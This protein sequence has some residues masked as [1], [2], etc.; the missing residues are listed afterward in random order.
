MSPAKIAYLNLIRRK[1]S[2]AILF[3]GIVLAVTT[4]GLLLRLYE[5]SADRFDGLTN[6]GDAIVGA[7]AGP[8]DLLLGM[9]NF[10]GSFPEYI[11][12][13]LYQTLKR[14]E[15]LQFEDKT[16]VGVQF[17]RDVFPF[18]LFAKAEDFRVYATSADFFTA[19]NLGAPKITA[20]RAPKA[21]NE[22]VI[23]DL[24]ARRFKLQVGQDILTGAWVGAEAPSAPKDRMTVT[25]IIEPTGRA[26][27]RIALA[28]WSAPQKVFAENAKSLRTPW[29]PNILHFMLVYLTPEGLKPLKNLINDRTVA[30]AVSVE[31]AT[32][33]LREL[34]GTGQELGLV[35]ASVILLLSITSVASIMVGRF[36]SRTVQLAVLRSLG[37]S[38]AD[39]SKVLI[40]EAIMITLAACFVGALFDAVL[41]P[42]LRSLLGA[43]IPSDEIVSSMI[44]QSW[45]VWA[46][47]VI[48]N[49]LSVLYPIWRISKQN[50][51]LSLRSL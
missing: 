31:S 38:K 51:H 8:I 10:E 40:L 27:D 21:S 41:F 9:E 1:F 16:S 20:G 34:T 25:G 44:W 49:I 3:I 50:I 11:P 43:N 6:A 15:G 26:W 18:V 17:V 29:G 23:G 4:S 32:A 47:V 22:I 5:L 42:E 33:K 45:P 7:K 12:L 36:E 19:Q 35:M 39:L 48:G 24:V 14:K 13:N 30:Q 46:S 2:T 37:Y 28:D